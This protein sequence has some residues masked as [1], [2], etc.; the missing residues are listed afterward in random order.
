MYREIIVEDT[1]GVSQRNPMLASVAL[2]FSGIVLKLHL[3]NICTTCIWVKLDRR[4]NEDT[5]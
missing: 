3:L 5:D 2:G 1:F 4:S